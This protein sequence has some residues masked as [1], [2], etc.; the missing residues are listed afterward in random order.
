MATDNADIM[1]RVEYALNTIRPF[2]H[3]DG[4]DIEVVELTDDMLLKVRLL[5]N[6]ETCP[7]SFSTMKAGVEESVK[8]EVPSITAVIAVD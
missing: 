8:K 3:K 1:D 6:C 2:L 4:G 7:M 5:G